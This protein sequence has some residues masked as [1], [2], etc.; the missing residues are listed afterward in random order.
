MTQMPI[1]YKRC[2][3]DSIKQQSLFWY[4]T[5]NKKVVSQVVSLWIHGI[6]KVHY[7]SVNKS[8]YQ[9]EN[10]RLMKQISI[11]NNITPLAPGDIIHW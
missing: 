9:W 7:I 10:A 11:I 6:S 5:I 8:N 1:P 4:H 3:S 2:L